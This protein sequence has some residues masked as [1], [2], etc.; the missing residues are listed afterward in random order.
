MTDSFRSDPPNPRRRL[1]LQ[2]LAGGGLLGAG[3]AGTGVM[4][5]DDAAA[6]TRAKAA[7]ENLSG[8]KTK[9]DLK[10][11][12]RSLSVDVP[13]QRTLLL[14]LREDLGLTGTKKGCNV[15][16]CGA[17]T[18]LL[19]GDPVYSCFMLT[20]DAVGHDITTIE[21]LEKNGTLH[22]VQ[23]GFVE[24]MGSQCGMCTSGMIMAGVGL[25]MRNPHPTP[26]EVKFALSGVLCRCGN[27]PHEMAAVLAASGQTASQEQQNAAFQT[28]AT[29]GLRA[30][31]PKAEAAP[32]AAVVAAPGDHQLSRLDLRIPALDGYVKATGRAR[33]SGDIGFHSDDPVR[34]PLFAKVVRSPFAHAAVVRI[35]D[36]EARKVKGYRGMITW[37]DVPQIKNDRHFLNHK[38]R[39]CGDAVAAIAADDQYAAQE[40]LN[41]LIVD[42]TPLSVHPDPEENLRTNDTSIHSG[43]PVAGF[44]GPQSANKPTVHEKKGDPD[45]GFSEADHTV[46]ARYVTGPQCHVPIEPHCVTAAWSGDHLT[47]WDSQQSIFRARH[48]ISDV[49]K[50]PKE[51]LRVV[52][53]Y[54]GGGFGGKC[55]DIHGKTMYQAIAATLASKLK[56]PVRYE[57]TLEELAFAEDTR[58]PFIF[59]LKA[60]VKKDGTITA[61]TCRAVQATGG[62]ASSGPA[63]VSVAAKAILG[64]YEIPNYEFTGFSVYTNSPVGGEMRGFGAPQAT[65]AMEMHIDKLAD[66]IGM[67]PLE[68]RQKNIAR[69][70]YKASKTPGMTAYDNLHS[71]ACLTAGAK[72]IGW[73][74]WQ[75]PS[76]KSGRLR[77]GLGIATGPE[78]SGREG[79]NGIVWIDRHGRVHVP[80]G[81]GNL[82]TLA[83]T[84]IASI[85]AQVLDMP[86]DQL[87]VT[88]GDTAR[89][90]WVYVTDASRSC[91]CDG[92][93]VYNAAQDVVH[94]LKV[95]AAKQ[96]NVSADTL[97]VKNGKVADAT[98]NSVDFRTLAAAAPAR[99]DF[100]PFYDPKTDINPVLNE[101]TGKLDK[102]PPD[103]LHPSTE[104]LAHEIAAKGGILGLGLYYWNAHVQSWGASFAEVDVDMETGQVALLRYAS[105]HDLGRVLYRTGAEAQ[106]HGGSVMGIGYGLHEALVLDPNTHI[107]INPSYIGLNP[108]TAL[109]YPEIIPVL[110]EAPVKAGPFGAKGLGENPILNPAPAI[111]NA[112]HNATGLWIDEIPYTWDRVYRALHPTKQV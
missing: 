9:I 50:I 86:A 112:I 37:K 5:Y 22:P 36:H 14:T 56:R 71:E 2:G 1:L 98:G 72:A 64:G 47:L 59:E 82:G 41:R 69:T 66:A 105:A 31:F 46:T 44:A 24:K 6:E 79:S 74:N 39:Y 40:A 97:S 18:V 25:L 62:Y 89:D 103:K 34:N 53:E 95:L 17:C 106:V 32:A 38:A 80:I 73:D 91:H 43:G 10:I 93:A 57:Y 107:P 54:V 109:D 81:T 76:K 65:Y 4:L 92:K 108:L 90:A 87:D 49:L 110:V 83:H 77:R 33:Y 28:A 7:T 63:V 20:R 96:L 84:G 19:D 35:D 12:G 27:Y 26:D 23:R 99:T 29:G 42:W 16:Q 104:Q 94:Q 3:L 85:V 101:A 75:P 15:G 55:T 51:K 88:W 70:G 102:H 48:M 13:D 100:T 68:F 60:G 11:N 21:G 45:K 111:G 61:L 8:A 67:N 58:N 78:H 52:S 30:P